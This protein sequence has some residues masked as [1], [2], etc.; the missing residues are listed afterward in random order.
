VLSSHFARRLSINAE[1]HLL[2]LFVILVDGSSGTFE[3][4]KVYL[5]LPL[6][7]DVLE[8]ILSLIR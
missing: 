6:K 3:L 8:N 4:I 1:Y 5:S 2:S 7:V